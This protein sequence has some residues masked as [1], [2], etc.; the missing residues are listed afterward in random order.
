M[1]VRDFVGDILHHVDGGA[2]AG[3]GTRGRSRS[4][5]ADRRGAP[6]AAYSSGSGAP[7][8]RPFGDPF[9]AAGQ[10][11]VQSSQH[12]A[13][14]S[15]GHDAGRGGGVSYGGPDGRGGR[16]GGYGGNRDSSS[17]PHQ[18]GGRYS[19]DPP[20]H[21][22]GSGSGNSSGG[23]SRSLRVGELPPQLMDL[24]RLS[25]HFGRYG[26]VTN[27]M[28]QASKRAAYVQMDSA[29][30]AQR[31]LDSRE[32]VC[33]NSSVR[34]SWARHDP[35]APRDAPQGA[36]PDAQGL[37]AANSAQLQHSAPVI[38]DAPASALSG[39]PPLTAAAA[40]S[41]EGVGGA[42]QPP[43]MDRNTAR[44]LDLVQRKGEELGTIASML[45]SYKE[46]LA[47]LRAGGA[48]LSPGDKQALLVQ[49]KAIGG[50]IK[51]KQAASAS[52]LETAKRAAESAAAAAAMDPAER[53]AA[54]IAARGGG[55]GRG[56]GR[57]GM[58]GGGAARPGRSSGGDAGDSVEVSDVADV[59]AAAAQALAGKGVLK[60]D[61]EASIA[62][63]QEGDEYDEYDGGEEPYG[64]GEQHYDE[65]GEGGADEVVV[66]DE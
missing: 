31:A 33:G 53:R 35:S 4:P 7:P 54:A 46:G 32:F 55:A 1:D 42:V 52:A 12:S 17:A 41:G 25:G 19:Q 36:Q 18:S 38:A 14:H 40:I 62:E 13:P 64:G 23:G 21:R 66:G 50:E 2:A 60:S 30:A 59:V 11:Q 24:A 45:A 20:A 56:R 43:T 34:L 44:V 29:E 63:E 47:K 65:E 28:L 8:P 51:R 3:W 26:V 15:G 48:D 6:P 10:V 58:R 39:A 9:A 57:G 61:A 37:A 49:L 27:I 22:G 5:P 16:Q